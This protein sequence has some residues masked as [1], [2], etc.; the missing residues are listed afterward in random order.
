M[1]RAFIVAW[2]CARRALRAASTKTMF[3]FPR[4]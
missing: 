3:A 2:K 1:A 4:A